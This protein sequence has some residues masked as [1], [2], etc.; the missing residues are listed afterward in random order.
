MA[1]YDLDQRGVLSKYQFLHRCI[2]DD[3]RKGNLAAGT[4]LPSKRSLANELHVSVNTVEHAYGLLVSEGYVQARRGSGFV[5]CPGRTDLQFFDNGLGVHPDRDLGEAGASGPSVRDTKSGDSCIR[6]SNRRSASQG[7]QQAGTSAQDRPIDLKANRCSLELF[8]LD[9]WS[10]LM[11]QVLSEQDPVLLETVPFNGLFVLRKAIANYLSEVKGITVSP[12]R[13]IVG[14]GTE[15][16]YGRLM[17]LLGNQR[18]IAIED[19]GYK[20]LADVSRS[21]GTLWKYIPLDDQGISVRVLEESRAK[22][23][24]VSPANHFPTGVTMSMQRRKELLDWLEAEPDRYVIEDDYDS[25]I[26]YGGRAPAALITQD[27][28]QRVI[29]LNTFSKTLVPSLRIS[30]M[31]LPK[32]L[33]EVYRQQ[34]SFYSCTVSSFEQAALAKFISEG[35]FERHI[36]RLRRY[37]RQHRQRVLDALAASRL[38]PF[39]FAFCGEV[40]TH[41]ILRISTAKSDDEIRRAII[42]RGASVALLSDYCAYP[43]ALHSHCLVVNF[44]SIPP[45]GVQD[46]LALLEEV[47]SEEVG[48]AQVS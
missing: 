7:F 12:S 33:M 32:A 22:V 28:Q 6:D 41:F 18:I 26:R 35:Y 27:T 23:V 3:I 30:Y 24:H 47:F 4:R 40:G 45:Y 21:F 1:T 38:A 25:E 42:K 2:R 43:S 15:Y 8:P 20:K 14:A 39:S 31:V 11:R 10:R 5:V 46:A 19:P 13:I 44:A 34:L 37:Y 48:Q 29:Y 36:N 16:I 9:T 17:Q